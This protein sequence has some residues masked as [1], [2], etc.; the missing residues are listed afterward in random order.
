MGH[1]V[2][3]MDRD[4]DFYVAWSSGVANVVF[5]G[6][7]AE[8]VEFEMEEAASRAQELAEQSIAKADEKGTDCQMGRGAYTDMVFRKMLKKQLKVAAEEEL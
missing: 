6:T 4:E 7:G 3:K 2:V 5:Y 1:V 8:L